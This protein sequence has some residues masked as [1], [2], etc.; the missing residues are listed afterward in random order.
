MF[1]KEYVL[2]GFA[3]ARKSVT[4]ADH[5]NISS[6][7]TVAFKNSKTDC[8]YENAPCDKMENGDA[9]IRTWQENGETVTD[10]TK[11]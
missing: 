6:L 7:T 8:V 5:R 1:T 10:C 11:N 9:G 4:R 2:G 3:A